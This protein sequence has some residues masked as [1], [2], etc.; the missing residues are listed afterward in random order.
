M[1]DRVGGFRKKTGEPIVLVRVNILEACAGWRAF[2]V[3]ATFGFHR[4]RLRAP[5]GELVGIWGMKNEGPAEP[6]ER[7]EN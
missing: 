6:G 1:E 3:P 2:A 4:D 5:K 7:L